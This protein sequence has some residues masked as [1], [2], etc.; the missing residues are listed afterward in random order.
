MGLLERKGLAAGY[1]P[2]TV[3]ITAWD[4]KVYYPGAQEMVIRLTADRETTRVL[5]AQMLGAVSGG[6]AK[7][8]DVVAAGLYAGMSVDEVND[9]DL[10]YT[11]PLGSPWDPVQTAAQAWLN[12]RAGKSSV[13]T[14]TPQM[15][16]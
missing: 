8:I 12:E 9:L 5:G 2:L 7:R 1:A 6:V 16:K 10:S 13:V 15:A 11:S 3:E 14:F 4:H